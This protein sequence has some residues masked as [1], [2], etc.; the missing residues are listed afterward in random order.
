MRRLLIAAFALVVV[1]MVSAAARQP[2]ASSAAQWT[3]LTDNKA[4]TLNQIDLLRVGKKLFVAWSRSGPTSK[5]DLMLTI[6]GENG[7]IEKT[8]PIVTGWGSIRVPALVPTSSGGVR[9]FFS[10]TRSNNLGEPLSGLNTATAP[11]TGTPA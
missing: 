10:G 1:F 8:V 9:V 7:T 11:A 5:Y 4:S 6:I 2:S 3:Q